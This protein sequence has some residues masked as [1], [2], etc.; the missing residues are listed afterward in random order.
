MT[1]KSLGLIETIGL[2]A[3][4]QAAD[5]A[6]KSANVE[7]VGY[8]LS[9]GSGMTVVK[10]RGD[11][12]AV[13]AAISAAESG[14]SLVNQVV[15]STVIARPAANINGIVE[16]ADTIGL[17]A[18]VKATISA[19]IQVQTETPS[20][21]ETQLAEQSAPETIE[22]EMETETPTPEESDTITETTHTEAEKN[23]EPS[24]KAENSESGTVGSKSEIARQQKKKTKK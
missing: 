22:S 20:L 23:Q 13:K 9:K 1:Q 16:T 12:A 21:T 24:E 7:L 6:L 18:P 14:A 4:I 5:V 15:S 3:A 10:I 2:A 11:V 8:E 17:A 19:D